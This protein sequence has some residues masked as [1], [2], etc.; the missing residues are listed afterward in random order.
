MIGFD[1]L[2]LVEFIPSPHIPH[3]RVIECLR[4]DPPDEGGFGGIKAI[5]KGGRF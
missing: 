5:K 4:M 3:K 2:P 1:T